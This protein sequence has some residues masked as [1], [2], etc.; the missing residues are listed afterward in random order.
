MYYGGNPRPRRGILVH[1]IINMSLCVLIKVIYVILDIHR[2]V[3][4]SNQTEGYYKIT[5]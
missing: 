1:V 3:G 2:K 4:Q 5:V